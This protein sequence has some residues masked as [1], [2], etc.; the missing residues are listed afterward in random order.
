MCYI[1]YCMSGRAVQ[2]YIRFKAD[3]TG[4]TEGRANEE[5]ENRI[6]SCIVRPYELRG[7]AWVR[8]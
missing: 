7:E 2:E 3:S 6:L 8:G 1:Y 5:A 4:S